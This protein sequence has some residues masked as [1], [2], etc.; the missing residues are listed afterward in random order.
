MRKIFLV[1]IFLLSLTASCFAFEPN[2]NVWEWIASDDE[3]G[4]FIEKKPGT[5]YSSPN[6][7]KYITTWLMTVDNAQNQYFL[8]KSKLKYR[9]KSIAD[10]YFAVYESATGKL[11]GSNNVPEN[12][13]P[14]IPGSFGDSVYQRACSKVGLRPY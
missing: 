14:I 13:K 8:T 9:D 2:P 3:F 10:V 12:Y 1:L 5:I 6:G 11:I 7:E 4:F